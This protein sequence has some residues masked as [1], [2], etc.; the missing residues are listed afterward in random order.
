MAGLARLR[1]AIVRVRREGPQGR[2]EGQREERRAKERLHRH[3]AE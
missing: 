1:T 3:E 2:K